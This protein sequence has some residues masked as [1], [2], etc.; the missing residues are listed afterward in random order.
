MKKHNGFTLIELLVVMSIIGILASI[1]IVSLERGRVQ[2]RDSKRKVDLTAV[3]SAMDMY[4]TDNK[5]YATTKV[6]GAYVWCSVSTSCPA[7][8]STYLSPIPVDPASNT[9]QIK[10]DGDQYKA[11][12]QSEGITATSTSSEITQK[13]GDFYD[14]SL[15]GKTYFQVSSS[16]A[17]L[18]WQ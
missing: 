13:A 5:A 9:Y 11:K 15:N 10:S 8:L 18:A 3:A 14:S 12:V 2:A 7:G 6:G 4:K 16:V 17:A 1:A